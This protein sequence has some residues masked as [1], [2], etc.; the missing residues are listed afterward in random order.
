MS[1]KVEQRINCAMQST[2]TLMV[3]GVGG[4][5]GNA[6]NSM[7]ASQ[8]CSSIQF[9]AANTDAQALTNSKAA[10][11][12]QLGSKITKGLGAGSNPDTGRR[13]AEEDIEEIKKHVSG[14]DILF[15]AAGLGGGTGSGAVPVIAK[16]AKE[17]GI[18]TVAVVTKPFTFEGKRRIK[19]AEEALQSLKNSVDTMIVVPNE[20]L[21]E[22]VDP[23]ISIVDAFG[24]SNS[25]LKQAVKGISDIIQKTGLVNV[26]FAD[27]RSI[28]KEMGIAIMGTGRSSGNDR[29]KKAAMEA[30]NSPLLENVSI[31]GA[32]GILF[33]ITGNRDLGLHEINDAAK[34]IY[35]LV[36][37]DANIILGS[38]ID[39]SMGDEIMVTVIATGLNY[40]QKIKVDEK[41]LS[42]PPGDFSK[43][44]Q[45]YKFSS[46][47]QPVF[48][49]K[50]MTQQDNLIFE[51]NV[52]D[53]ENNRPVSVQEKDVKKDRSFP[54]F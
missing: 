24:L 30:I 7:I 32:K 16:A 2:P 50:N 34:I 40:E 15:L 52:V 21:L 3:L 9:I 49:E 17:M 13:A 29:A 46:G 53:A 26:D 54:F 31:E 33:N 43:M 41:S 10:I 11:T 35:E 22:V 23:K 48:H 28:M 44:Q 37:D 42:Y 1:E 5:G 51:K 8:D 38:V 18:L 20:R 6:I 4:A 27:V 47:A 36:N 19:H 39:E 25:I 45:A 12:I 14:A